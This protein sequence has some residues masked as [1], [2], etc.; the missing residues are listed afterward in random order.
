MSI[1]PWL[2][3]LNALCAADAATTHYGIASGRAYEAVMPTQTLWIVDSANAAQ[4]AAIDVS[5]L[6][7]R[8][9]H[10]RLAWAL[11]IAGTAARSWAVAHNAH[12]LRR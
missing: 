11:V 10:P 4:A 2:V 9:D 12:E 8:K 3:A 6:T 1:V 7:L 5:V